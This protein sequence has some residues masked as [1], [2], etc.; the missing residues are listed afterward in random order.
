[1]H[2]AVLNRWEARDDMPEDLVGL[3]EAISELRSE[4][5]AALEEG[6]NESLRFELGPVEMEFV[7]E[8]RR[9][10]AG[11]AGLK[12]WVVSVGGSASASRGSTHRVTLTLTPKK[13]GATPLIRDVESKQQAGQ[14]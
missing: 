14:R 5:T 1:M 3:A 2:G 7:L 9:E 8:L 12:F 13:D 10:G 4:L 11:E 6:K